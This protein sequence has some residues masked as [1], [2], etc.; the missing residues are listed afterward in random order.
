MRI[1]D[2]LDKKVLIGFVVL[3]ALLVGAVFYFLNPSSPSYEGGPLSSLQS[4]SLDATLGRELLAVLAKLKSTTL[5]TSLFS[6]P[7]YQSLK[8]FGVSIA[9]QPVG[10]RNPFA[11][12]G[13]AGALPPAGQGKKVP[14]PSK[15]TSPSSPAS[16][17]AG[18]GF[19]VE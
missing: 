1:L 4:S 18:G 11:E 14:A 7:V 13:A 16:P 17:S 19:D 9:A 12:L 6:D 5:D 8:D 3:A 2:H 10:R 15:G